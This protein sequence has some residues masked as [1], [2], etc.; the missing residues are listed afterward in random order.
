MRMTKWAASR[1]A[2]PLASTVL[3]ACL[4][5][6]LSAAPQSPLTLRQAYELALQ[7]DAVIRGARAA[8]EG[9][10]ERLPQA[11]A[12]LLPNVSAGATANRNNLETTV[13]GLGGAE[14]N[15][16]QRYN[17]NFR[18]LT[19]RQPLFRPYLTASVRQAEAEVA[20]ANALLDREL[21]SVAVRVFSAY[22]EGLLAQD[23]LALVLAQKQAYSTQLE[24]AR[25]RLAAGAGVRTDIDEAQARLDMAVA[26]ELEAR[27]NVDFTRSQMQALVD[28]PVG[29]LAPVD[30]ARLRVATSTGERLQD[31]TD[32]AEQSSP[33]LRSLRARR[34]AALQA[35]DKARS[36]HLPTLDAIAQ[37]SVSDSN[38]VTRVTSRFENK[39]IGVQ[40]N[41]PI[42]AGGSVNSQVRQALAEVEQ[43]DQA[44]E[45]TR[46][47]LGLRVQ[48]E[49]RAMSEGVLRVLALEQAVRSA[50]TLVE[51]ST[52]S[53]AG[54]SR[55]VVDV[56]NAQEQRVSAQRDL[57]VARYSYILA[58]IRLRALSGEADERAVATVDAFFRE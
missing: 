17:S 28:Q 1:G 18:A 9:R 26:L 31:W 6:P 27:Q 3:A 54:G 37:W 48:K 39:T 13:P 36:G 23:Q 22:L 20:D 32:R 53:F 12:Q 15:T 34:E 5:W 52:R 19:V 46:R 14:L 58:Y 2:R 8:A 50:E 42:F 56:L 11:R 44:L 16:H 51:S 10:R 4:A 35:V 21:Q 33:E 47:D 30:E 57:A 24:A 38:E 45:A 41:V 29:A 7:R 49:Y 43:A 25:R 55:T 40:L